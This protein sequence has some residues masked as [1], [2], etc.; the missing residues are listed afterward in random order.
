MRSCRSCIVWQI[1]LQTMR[2]GR[3]IGL[4]SSQTFLS[5]KSVKELWREEQMKPLTWEDDLPHTQPN[6]TQSFCW[7]LLSPKWCQYLSEDIRHRSHF[8]RS[9][10]PLGS[11]PKCIHTSTKSMYNKLHHRNTCNNFHSIPGTH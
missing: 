11:S 7:F 8:R 1:A 4:T 9:K 10:L 5:A 2:F 3:K 6:S